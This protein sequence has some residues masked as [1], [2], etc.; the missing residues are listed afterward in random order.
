MG[1]T[2][3]EARPDTRRLAAETSGGPRTP[4]RQLPARPSTDRDRIPRAWQ[5]LRTAGRYR[6]LAV[7]SAT[8]FPDL[9]PEAITLV[10]EG[11]VKLV[12]LAENGTTATLAVRS[13][14]S[15]VSHFG[16]RAAVRLSMVA[17]LPSAVVTVSGP[18]VSATLRDHSWLV[19][20]LLEVIG[21][22]AV[23]SDHR[24]LDHVAYDVPER[25]RR[26]LLRLAGLFPSDAGPVVVPVSQQDLADLAGVSREAT[27]RE[28]R[29]LRESGAVRTGRSRIVVDRA[30]L[31]AD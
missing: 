24:L 17:V 16:D 23:E 12:G 26:A 15:I 19:A 30:D 5:V 9:Q 29:R 7:G 18:R 6:L 14:G 22:G 1:A 8:P 31:I 20:P 27:A 11:A 10:V 2:G 4:A 3:H 13:A 25:I 28:L 21:G